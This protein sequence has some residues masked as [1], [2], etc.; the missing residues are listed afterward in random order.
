MSSGEVVPADYKPA[1]QPLWPF[2][3][4]YATRNAANDPNYGYYGTNTVFIKMKDGSTQEVEKS[5]N[6]DVYS[7]FG[8]LHPWINQPVL[9]TN[10]WTVDASITKNFALTER[11]RLRLQ[12][13]FFNALN[14]A[15]N[16]FTPLDNSGIVTNQYSQNSPRV[17]QLS[18]RFTW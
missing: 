1:A 17:M 5:W 16:N 15:G 18:A 2:P 11:F 10:T 8:A 12:A 4:D 14:V 6:G 7:G 3:A 13:D 9:S